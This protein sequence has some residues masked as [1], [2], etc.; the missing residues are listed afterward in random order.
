[1]IYSNKIKL[2]DAGAILKSNLYIMIINNG[3]IV[4]KH[5]YTA[6]AINLYVTVFEFANMRSVSDK[7]CL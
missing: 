3:L 5:S 7:H 1:M 6:I 2:N 4:L